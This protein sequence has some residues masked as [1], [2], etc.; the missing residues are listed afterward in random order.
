MDPIFIWFGVASAAGTTA[1]SVTHDQSEFDSLGNRSPRT[2]SKVTALAWRVPLQ[3][4]YH[5][6]LGAVHIS[7]SLV[8]WYCICR[9]RATGTHHA[10]ASAA[11]AYISYYLVLPL[12]A[13]ALTFALSLERECRHRKP[14]ARE[15]LPEFKSP[16]YACDYGYSGEPALHIHIIYIFILRKRVLFIL[17]I[18]IYIYVYINVY[19]WVSFA[20]ILGL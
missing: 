10:L 14:I 15:E 12:Q 6:L 11:S 19:I 4:V 16:T 18:Y 1:I 20:S 2:L 13:A 3:H 9:C 5:I 7:C 8:L 17:Q